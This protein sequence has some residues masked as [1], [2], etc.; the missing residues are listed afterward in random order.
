MVAPLVFALVAATAGAAIPIAD[1]P[2]ELVA[3]IGA[4]PPPSPAGAL[5]ATVDPGRRSEQILPLEPSRW[6]TGLR[7]L[8][9]LRVVLQGTVRKGRLT[10]EAPPRLHRL[11]DDPLDE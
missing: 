1:G 7:S 11:S 6:E 4:C 2:G 9:R 10:L 5:C 3:R 8:G